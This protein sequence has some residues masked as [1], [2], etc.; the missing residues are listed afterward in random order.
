MF[1]VLSIRAPSLAGSA[2]LLAVTLLAGACSSSSG[3]TGSAM[4]GASGSGGM[5]AGAGSAGSAGSSGSSGSS[6]AEPDPEPVF[7]EEEWDALRELSPEVL[8]GPPPDIS[9][10]FADDPAAAAFGQRLFF[11]P[12]FAGPLLDT[13]NDGSVQ[14]LG[15][16]G[17]TGRVACSGCHLPS[18]D[19]SDTRS[20]QLQISLGAGWGRRRAPSLLDVGQASLFLWDGRRDALFNQVFGPI[21]SVVEMNSS[22]L[23]TAQ[24]V[25]R[26]HKEEYEALFGPLPP[27]DDVT[28]FPELTAE[29]SG[30]VPSNQSDPQPICDGPF[31]GRPGDEAEFDG[32]AP[33]DQDAVT[34]VVVNLGKALGAYQRLLTC[35]QGPFDAWMQGDESAVSRAAK[36]GAALFVGKA[37]CVSCHSG[38]FMSDQEFHN[39]GLAPEIVQQGFLD[40]DDQGA[41]KGLA[42]ALQDPLN[43]RG[44]Y[45]DGDDG[46]LPDEVDPSLAGAFRTPTLRC[47]ARRPNFMHTGQIPSLSRVVAFFNRGGFSSGYPG[48]N[49]LTSLDLTPREQSDLVAFLETL[50]GPGADP[51]LGEPP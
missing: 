20:F 10:R 18:G 6:P 2:S 16:V 28:R 29:N 26:L 40:H 17:D 39:V 30:C 45:S 46:R 19:F 42:E 36:R 3:E 21:E 1:A 51:K 11:E 23:F 38:P 43:S 44:Q 35:G 31:R 12:R 34:R 7:T 41:V 24:Q 47:V 14:A 49:E 48:K 9:N 37:K 27:F 25:Y 32:L 50:N 15:K 22:R 13:D 8:P 33:E 5:P 4:A